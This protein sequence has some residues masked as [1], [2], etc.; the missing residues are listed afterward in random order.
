[1]CE[2]EP[3]GE[4]NSAQRVKFLCSF[5]GSILPRPSDG[6]L[7]YVGGETRIVCVNR[8]I[9]YSELMFKM[10]EFY[11]QALSLKYQLPE[12][13]LDALVSVLCDDDLTNMMEEYDKLE[14]TDGFTRLRVFLFSAAEYDVSPVCKEADPE[15]RYVD[16]L[17]GS[18]EV[19]DPR[20]QSELSVLGQSDRWSGAESLN[21]A[22]ADDGSIRAQAVGIPQHV[23]TVLPI[24]PRQAVIHVASPPSS[25]LNHCCQPAIRLGE[26][27]QYYQEQSWRLGNHLHM[28]DVLCSASTC[29]PVTHL[30]DPYMDS[31]AAVGFS[32]N[33]H[34]EVIPDIHRGV[35][36]NHRHKQSVEV[37]TTNENYCGNLQQID[38]QGGAAPRVKLHDH[39]PE[40][41]PIHDHLSRQS[42]MHHVA[43]LHQQHMH[44]AA[45]HCPSEVLKDCEFACLKVPQRKAVLHHP[46]SGRVNESLDWDKEQHLLNDDEVERSWHAP[47]CA[48]GIQLLHEM[49]SSSESEP[50]S[51]FCME[52]AH[53][54]GEHE[55]FLVSQQHMQ[56]LRAPNH[57]TPEAKYERKPDHTS[58]QSCGHL[59][60]LN[61]HPNYSSSP[62]SA[63][64][65]MWHPQLP[66]S[67][68]NPRLQEQN[69]NHLQSRFERN[70]ASEYAFLETRQI[71]S[72]VRGSE[73]YHEHTV[74]YPDQHRSSMLEPQAHNS[75]SEYHPGI[76]EGLFMQNPSVKVGQLACSRKHPQPHIGYQDSVEGL[77]IQNAYVKVDQLAHFREHA[78]PHTGYQDRLEGLS[79]QNRSVK[80]DQLASREHAQPHTGYHDRVDRAR[81]WVLQQRNH[82][83]EESNMPSVVRTPGVLAAEEGIPK[84]AGQSNYLEHNSNCYYELQPEDSY[85][86]PLSGDLCKH[87]ASNQF[88]LCTNVPL[89]ANSTS[90]HRNFATM[91]GRDHLQHDLKLEFSDNPQNNTMIE[92]HSDCTSMF[93]LES[94]DGQNPWSFSIADRKSS[95]FPCV[96]KDVQK[97][98]RL[99]C[100][101]TSYE[102]NAAN[103][104][105]V[106]TCMPDDLSQKE[107]A[108]SSDYKGKLPK[109]FHGDEGSKIVG[110][111]DIKS[112][113][114][115]SHFERHPQCG[116]LTEWAP[117][118]SDNLG[119]NGVISSS[120]CSCAITSS[121][122][123]LP[124]SLTLSLSEVSPSALSSSLPRSNVPASANLPVYDQSP[125]SSANIT[126]PEDLLS[127][128]ERRQ[129]FN[130]SKQSDMKA[131]GAERLT[132]ELISSLRVAGQNEDLGNRMLENHLNHR[133]EVD[134]CGTARNVDSSLHCS[135]LLCT[136]ITLTTK[137]E[138]KQVSARST[139]EEV[140]R[141]VKEDDKSHR[142]DAEENLPEKKSPKDYPLG[143]DEHFSSGS[144]NT[145]KNDSSVSEAHIFT[146]GLQT[147]RNDDLEE[148]REL[149]SGTYG[150]VYHGKWKG[151][152]VAIKRI[153][154]SCFTGRQSEQERMIA[155][156]WR[157]ACILGQLHHPNVVAFYGIVQDGPGGTLATVTEYMVNGSLKQVLHKKDRTIDRRKRLI[158]AMDVAFGMEYLH[159]KNIVHFDLKCDNLLVNMKDPHRPICKIGD[160]GLSKIKQRTLVS[161]GVRGTLPWMAPELL[162]GKSGMVTDKVDVYSFGIVMWELLTGEEPY[163]NMHCG[164][165]IG[166]ILNDTLR[167]SIPSWCEPA[168]RSL[169]ERCWSSDPGQRPSFP[170]IAKELRANAASINLK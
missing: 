86:A 68:E 18:P 161:A 138:G 148:I 149:G 77:S 23:T 62:S 50:I 43:V 144:V 19:G 103:V 61:S 39:C 102:I 54:R 16:A 91:I 52:C 82:H 122:V 40:D 27:D 46:A 128:N 8:D 48:S 76:I 116:A 159:G 119:S 115:P 11:D 151:S 1:M 67:G 64:H 100:L 140:Y 163:A 45:G 5:G 65:V 56:M 121:G 92:T 3:H 167:P 170:D 94:T 70:P 98:E 118:T 32:F 168:W 136:S 88:E 145:A 34:S 111:E 113:L 155:D 105:S 106:P 59:A 80:V 55:N 83:E 99:Q 79:I 108:N 21:F 93:H 132:E 130:E 36:L 97:S 137:I 6:K 141:E 139:Q 156:F 78:P 17:N 164:E 109:D 165:I 41:H 85:H 75:G 53:L 38:R 90:R 104:C 63:K 71:L 25:P 28:Q 101:Y 124:E 146:Q 142:P 87:A 47:Y 169:M 147:I 66:F 13:D 158:L 42:H 20:S 12:E 58:I 35:V 110:D 44:Q 74:H 24:S 150:T 133:P 117:D 89:P 96:P 60:P 72:E 57:Q 9:S 69:L 14:A 22:S 134:T 31:V 33:S 4:D 10:T 162:S 81:G 15:Q 73:I 95:E 2:S 49:S 30:Q 123:F 160:L 37:F 114:S 51:D 125:A 157:E 29:L 154:A 135:N 131:F 120:A 7:R 129:Q 152:D 143:L 127:E 26:T 84:D 126:V 166:G 112:V 153:K 107:V